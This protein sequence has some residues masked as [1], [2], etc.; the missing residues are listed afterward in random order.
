MSKEPFSL[1]A[2]QVPEYPENAG[3]GDV[4]RWMICVMDPCDQR[5]AFIAGCL[6]HFLKFGGLTLKQ[7]KA[8]RK[9][10]VRIAE[11]F[12]AGILVCQNSK[13]TDFAPEIAHQ[14]TRH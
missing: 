13:A 11:D 14:E 2:H 10:L 8:C 12:N 7:S 1:L 4:L 6:S 5:L 3:W 9:I